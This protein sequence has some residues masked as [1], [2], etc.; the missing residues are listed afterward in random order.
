VKIDGEFGPQTE[1]AVKKFQRAHGLK[2]DGIAGQKTLQKLIVRLK[3]GDR[4]AAVRVL[5]HSLIGHNGENEE[6]LKEYGGFGFETERAVREQQ[7]W[8]GLKVNGIVGPETWC[9]LLGGKV[10]KK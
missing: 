1:A 2:V 8:A 9:I 10:V 5:Q 4:G 3:R 7:E 6:V